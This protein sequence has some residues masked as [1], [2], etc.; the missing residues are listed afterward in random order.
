[1]PSQTIQQRPEVGE[2]GIVGDEFAEIVE[3]HDG[4]V[5]IGFIVFG[6]WFAKDDTRESGMLRPDPDEGILGPLG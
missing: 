5:L 2:D 4:G 6:L 3:V 1:L